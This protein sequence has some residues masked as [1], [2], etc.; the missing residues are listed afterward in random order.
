[1]GSSVWFPCLAKP[2]AWNNNRNNKNKVT[3]S[4]CA[5]R[6]VLTGRNQVGKNVDSES[7][8]LGCQPSHLLPGWPWPQDILFDP[9]R[10]SIHSLIQQVY[11]FILGMHCAACGLLVLQPGDEPGPSAVKAWSPN[12][13]TSREFPIQQIFIECLS[14][15]RYCS[16]GWWSNSEQKRQKFLPLWRWHSKGSYPY[17]S[18]LNTVRVQ[19]GNIYRCLAIGA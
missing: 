15:V 19:W 5:R 18:H 2:R 16:W 8:V 1:M 11:V 17:F 10:G 14:C 6:T 4:N 3:T 13:W 9:Y 7:E 12:C